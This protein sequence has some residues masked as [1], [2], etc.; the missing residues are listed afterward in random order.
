MK[1]NEDGKAVPPTPGEI[2]TL[3]EKLRSTIPDEQLEHSWRLEAL[4]RL[5]TL[6][7][8]DPADFHMLWIEPLLDA[9]ASLEVAYDCIVGSYLQPN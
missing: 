7:Q 1:T 8:M 6:F 5:I 4:D 9:G 2:G 3:R